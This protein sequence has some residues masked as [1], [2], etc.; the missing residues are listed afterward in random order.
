MKKNRKEVLPSTKA[1]ENALKKSKNEIYVLKLYITG[2]TPQSV[3]AID[4][5]IKICEEHLSGRYKLE[6][7]DLYRQPQLAK[8]EQII[9]SPTLIKKLP[10]PLRRIIGNLT[11]VEKLLIG[12]DLRI[13]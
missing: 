3:K 7:I 12:L 1:Y 11:N 13:D 10:T 5:I 2:S 6:I 9:A 8:D 4:N